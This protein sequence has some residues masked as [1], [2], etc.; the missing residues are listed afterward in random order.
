MDSSVYKLTVEK[1]DELYKA[2]RIIPAKKLFPQVNHSITWWE[3]YIDNLTTVWKPQSSDS[4]CIPIIT[5]TTKIS[6]PKH[7]TIEGMIYV[8]SYKASSSTCEGVA[9]NIAHNVARRRF[10][11]IDKEESIWNNSQIDDGSRQTCLAYT[12]HEFS[13]LKNHGRQNATSS[14]LWSFVR[15]P[16]KR[17]LSHVFHF[18]IGRSKQFPPS[19][20]KQIINATESKLKGYQTR[21]LSAE[22]GDWRIKEKK[23][24][25]LPYQYKWP[26]WFLRR[27]PEKI[28]PYL[29]EKIFQ[30]YDFLGVTDRMDESLA[31]MVLLW[32]LEARDVIVL[33]SKRSGSWDAGGGGIRCTRIPK[34]KTTPAIEKYF[35][36]KHPLENVDYLLYHV[37]N[38]SLDRTIES[39]GQQRVKK[40]VRYI[41]DLRRV[42][43]TSCQEKAIFPCS[44]NG[45]YRPVASARSCYVQDAGCAHECVDATLKRYV[46]QGVMLQRTV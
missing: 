34:A 8:K 42:A 10:P 46:E 41:Q 43:E 12:R 9:L 13:D 36:T 23:N 21:Y 19:D 22:T 26:R 33:S 31:V 30:R 37:V 16:R 29:K 35:Q 4:W 11:P 24:P 25:H 38:K 2:V 39:L 28:M 32:G 18:M 15:H 14:L 1:E 3:N 7:K 6:P 27:N 17:D 44:S 5:N 45:V 20:S 40:M